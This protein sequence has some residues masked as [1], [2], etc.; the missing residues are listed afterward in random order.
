MELAI[1][2]KKIDNSVTNQHARNGVKKCEACRVLEPRVL[3]KSKE[4]LL[5]IVIIQ[6]IIIIHNHHH[7]NNQRANN[8]KT[9]P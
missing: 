9:N 5:E 1:H 2:Q 3:V 6:T 7:T 8:L 4:F